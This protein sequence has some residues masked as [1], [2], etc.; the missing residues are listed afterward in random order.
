MADDTRS[1]T[2]QRRE[3][4]SQLSAAAVAGLAMS[5]ASRAGEEQTPAALPTIQLGKHRVSR[6]VAGWNPIGGYSYLGAHTNRH[7]KEYFTTD[8]TVEFLVNCAAAGITL[9]QFSPAENTAEILRKV[10]ERGAKMEFL[11]L[12]GNRQGIAAMIESTHPIAMAHHGG[13][14]DS[15]FAQGK[16]GEVHDYVKA[17]HDRGVLAGVS[18]HNPDCI[19]R[20]ADEGW[21]VDFFMTCFYFLTRKHA[22]GSDKDKDA[23]PPTLQI[24]YPFYRDDPAAM[25]QV[26]RQVRQPCFGFKILAAGRLAGDSGSVREAFR[27][28]FANI[29]PIDG[30]IVGMYPRFFDEIRANADFAREFGKV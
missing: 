4:L 3:F 5:A 30:V 10:R 26:V 18:A 8:R 14:T 25:T 1:R 6:L 19:R 20:I 29:K 12:D 11:C 22:P 7:M 27:F 13:A 16:S 23:A 17:A 28:A 24:D 9:H 21:E 15:L 2:T